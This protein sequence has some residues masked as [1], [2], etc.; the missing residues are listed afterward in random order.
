MAYLLAGARGL[1]LA[2]GQPLFGDFIAF[3]SAGRAALDGAAAQ[4]H[5]VETIARYQQKRRRRA[6]RTLRRGIRRRRFC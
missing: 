4:V 3:W 6:R 5:E 2:N 1:V